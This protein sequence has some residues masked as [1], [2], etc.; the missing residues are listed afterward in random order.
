MHYRVEIIALQALFTDFWSNGFIDKN[1]DL[2]IYCHF[3]NFLILQGLVKCCGPVHCATSP[4]NDTVHSSNDCKRVVHDTFS[5][6][7]KNVK[8]RIRLFLFFQL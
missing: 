1:S 3:A 4:E 6:T 8:K 7:V 5:T 2:L